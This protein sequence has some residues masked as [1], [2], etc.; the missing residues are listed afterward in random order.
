MILVFLF[1][2]RKP[3]EVKGRKKENGEK[4]K[5]LNPSFTVT[6]LCAEECI[7]VILESLTEERD[8]LLSFPYSAAWLLPSI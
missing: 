1:A 2:N 4:R 6:V 7:V 5:T 8:E 3:E